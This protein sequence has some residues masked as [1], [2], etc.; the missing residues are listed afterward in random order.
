MMGYEEF[1]KEAGFSDS[2]T[3]WIA[4]KICCGMSLD[5]ATKAAYDP[6]WGWEP[7]PECT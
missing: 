5:E 1:L 3:N 4:W 7:L 2:R 6:V